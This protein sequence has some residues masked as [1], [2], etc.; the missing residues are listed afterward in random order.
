MNARTA[1]FRDRY[2]AALHR[3]LRDGGEDSL[4]A[5]Y[6]LGRAAVRNELSV[7]DLA[8]IHNEKGTR[9]GMWS[10][11]SAAIALREWFRPAWSEKLA[12]PTAS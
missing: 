7:M 1:D 2:A 5:A 11:A 12:A 8:A 3:A 9:R 4:S 6:E 10:D